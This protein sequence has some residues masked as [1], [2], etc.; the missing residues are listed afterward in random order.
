M[1]GEVTCRDRQEDT[2]TAANSELFSFIFY[3]LSFIFFLL[4][5][6]FILESIRKYSAGGFNLKP[7]GVGH[8]SMDS[9]III[10]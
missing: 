1:A 5:F 3:L 2:A 10:L 8:E 6:F 9:C 4:S 7:K